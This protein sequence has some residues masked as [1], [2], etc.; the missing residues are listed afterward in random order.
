MRGKI[1]GKISKTGAAALGV[2]ALVLTAAATVAVA[3]PFFGTSGDDVINGTPRHDYISG[4][5]GNDTLNGFGRADLIL[6]GPGNDT[7]NAGGGNDLVFGGAGDDTLNGGPGNDR[8]FAQRGVDTVNGGPGN[9]DL[10]ALARVDVTGVPGEP[11]DTLT[12]GPGND[13][14]HVRDG[15]PDHVDC[16]DGHDVVLADF[17]DVVATNCEVV[18]RH[19]PRTK[20]HTKDD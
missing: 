20:Q 9:D 14:F 17:K 12:G 2:T 18:K 7:V 3:Q 15:E 16:G 6:G 1:R 11:G 4:R 8:I 19:A 5:A 13:V 10:W